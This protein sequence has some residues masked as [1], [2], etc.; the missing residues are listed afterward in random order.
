MNESDKESVKE[1]ID[2]IDKLQDQLRRDVV[3][4]LRGVDPAKLS[5]KKFDNAMSVVKRVSDGI[6]KDVKKL[7]KIVK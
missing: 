3:H 7:K 2:H 6:D 4:P 5:S 1:L